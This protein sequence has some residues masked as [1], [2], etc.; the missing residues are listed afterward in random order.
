MSAEFSTS[1]DLS[2]AVSVQLSS[3]SG[4]G[5]VPGTI[6]GLAPA[7]TYWVRLLLKAGSKPAVYS[8]TVSFTTLSTKAPPALGAAAVS[9]T[10]T[11]ATLVVP[12]ACSATT[13]RP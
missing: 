9:T 4:P 2:D 1:S 6:P 10:K 3:I 8:Q 7:T 12:V 5:G 11:N 13:A